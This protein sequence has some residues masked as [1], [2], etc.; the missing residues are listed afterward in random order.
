MERAGS[1]LLYVHHALVT[2]LGVWGMIAEPS[3]SVAAIIGGGLA[4]RVWSLMFAAFGASALFCRFSTRVGFRW[5][6][7]RRQFDAT[8]SEALCLVLIGLAYGLF[9]AVL[10]IT[11]LEPPLDLGVIQTALAL[12]ASSVFL[13]ACTAIY[14]ATLRRERL[15]GHA[16][17]QAT[18]TEVA[19]QVRRPDTGD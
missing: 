1:G 19:R 3:P 13:G 8:R 16:Q 5:R 6:G 15:R 12:L 7:K 11:A 18:L 14:L 2:G 9:S 10:V 4:S 17:M